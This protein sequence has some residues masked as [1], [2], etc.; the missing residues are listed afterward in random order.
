MQRLAAAEGINAGIYSGAA[1][2]VALQSPR[3]SCRA[4]AWS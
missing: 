4:S 2:H 1:L 3:S